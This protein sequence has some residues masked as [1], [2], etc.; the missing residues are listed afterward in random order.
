LAIGIEQ[1]VYLEE[2][3][4]DF[5]QQRVEKEVKVLIKGES[6]KGWNATK[7]LNSSYYDNVLNSRKLS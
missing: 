6:G 5:L 7:T 2:I 1:K 3:V 4:K